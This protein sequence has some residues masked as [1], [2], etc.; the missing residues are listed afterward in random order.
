LKV[1]TNSPHPFLAGQ[2]VSVEPSSR[3]PR[4][5]RLYTPA[6]APGGLEIELHARLIPGGPVS[7]ALVRSTA[8]GDRLRLG[9]PFGRMR[10]DPGSNQ[11]LL[12]VAGSTGLAPLKAMIEQV[13][14]D[15]GR[16][17]HLYFGARSIR[18]IYD[19]K[20]LEELAE[21]YSWLTV[22]IAVSD[23]VRWKGERGL[24]GAVAAAAG[25][26]EGHDIYICGSPAMVESTIKA[27]VSS[28][29]RES[30]IR[31]EEFGDA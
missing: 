22:V 27:L 4:E 26:W 5:W 15:G 3:R 9:P 8:A 14:R 29:V 19:R 23:D 11:P 1:R 6:N 10:L 28:G 21:R 20:S 17:T 12:M 2:S 13:A 24:I 25:P 30:D 18:E 7:T 31:F 16:P